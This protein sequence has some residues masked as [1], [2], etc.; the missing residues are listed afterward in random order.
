MSRALSYQHFFNNTL[1]ENFIGYTV[2][3]HV[4]RHPVKAVYPAYIKAT[5]ARPRQWRPRAERGE[6]SRG[7]FWWG[8]ILLFIMWVI[9]RPSEQGLMG[10]PRPLDA[11]MEKAH[12]V[13]F[14]KTPSFFIPSSPAQM[15]GKLSHLTC[16]ARIHNSGASLFLPPLLCS[17]LFFFSHL[18]GSRWSVEPGPS[19]ARAGRRRRRKWAHEK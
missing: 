5:K 13:P 7:R 1:K 2:L 6:P 8:H 18:A 10:P 3:F 14:Q 4:N 9:F 19:Q 12:V 11:R 17:F 16:Q 15:S